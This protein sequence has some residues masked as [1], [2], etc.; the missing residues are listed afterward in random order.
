[1]IDVFIAL[2]SNLGD[3][4]GS[5]ST[6][7]EL[8][9]REPAFLLRRASFAYETEPV[10]P[11]Q[12][13]YLNAVVRVGTLLSPRA[14]LRKL[15]EIEEVMGRVRRERWAAR[16]I[17]LDLLFFGDRT[18]HEPGLTLPHARLHE[19]AFVLA[20]LAELAP[21]LIHPVL[22]RTVGALLE[23]L[24]DEVRRGVRPYRPIPRKLGDDPE[25]DPE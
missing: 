24:P 4:L 12:P 9:A 16:D 21:E 25:P 6:A 19:R 5:L 22:G 11:P 20:P 1:M 8:L 7:V 17:D 18:L 13:R 10:G 14:T 15:L 23:A 3:R 2:G